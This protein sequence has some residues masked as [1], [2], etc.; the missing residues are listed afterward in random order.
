MVNSLCTKVMLYLDC[1]VFFN[2]LVDES[3]GRLRLN[4]FAGISSEQAQEIEWLDYGVA[5][6][7]CAARDRCRVVAENILETPDPRTELVK[8]YGI[9]AYACHPLM[10]QDRLLG[11][12]SF[13]TRTRLASRMRSCRS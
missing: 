2:F 5:V 11:T 13:G 12:L 9:Q 7:G 6:C 3:A 1:D 8:S 4:A 10:A